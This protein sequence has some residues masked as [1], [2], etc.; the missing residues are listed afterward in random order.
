VNVADAGGGKV[1]VVEADNEG[2]MGFYL[3]N[4]FKG[5]GVDGDLAL[6]MKVSSAR[7]AL[8]P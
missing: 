7:V 5:T 3:R 1:I 4:G 6:F 8:K 2:L